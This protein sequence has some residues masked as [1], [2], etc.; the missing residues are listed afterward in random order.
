MLQKL[1]HET[2]TAHITILGLLYVAGSLLGLVAGCLFMNR[3]G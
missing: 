2:I 1:N 3:P